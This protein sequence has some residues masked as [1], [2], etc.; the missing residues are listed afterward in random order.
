MISLRLHGLVFVS[1]L[2]MVL[3]G[4]A[5]VVNAEDAPE[6]RIVVSA[7]DADAELAEKVQAALD[8]AVELQGLSVEASVQGLEVTLEGVVPSEEIKES[9]LDTVRSADERIEI[10]NLLTVV[11]EETKDDENE[12]TVIGEKDGESAVQ[13][14]G[15]PVQ[16]AAGPR[17][18]IR[19]RIVGRWYGVP[20]LQ[21]LIRF[22]W[23]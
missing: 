7:S 6:T 12:D 8:D 10:H 4:L 20:R 17:Q 2:G 11:A 1:A 9:L 5:G 23:R 13:K 18:V 21:S 16:K 15:S 14:L 19:W 3:S 22:R